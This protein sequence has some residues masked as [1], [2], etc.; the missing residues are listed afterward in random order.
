MAW[1]DPTIRDSLLTKSLDVKDVDAR[2][3][4]V[5]G[6]FL[7]PSTTAKLRV[8][9]CAKAGTELYP[10]LMDDFRSRQDFISILL[11]GHTKPCTG[12][13]RTPLDHPTF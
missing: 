3:K 12:F 7:L 8:A 4:P 9:A 6:T 10:G 5:Q 1:L 2:V 11:G 13:V